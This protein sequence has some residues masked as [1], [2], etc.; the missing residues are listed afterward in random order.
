MNHELPDE[1]DQEMKTARNR[2]GRLIAWTVALLCSLIAF[3][4]VLPIWLFGWIA[5]HTL[6]LFRG[7]PSLVPMLAGLAL[8]AVK[9]PE[10]SIWIIL[11]VVAMTTCL[12]GHRETNFRNYGF[13][14]TLFVWACWILFA[15]NFWLGSNTSIETV[16]DPERPVVCLGDSLTDYG[17]PKEL[18]KLI[19]VPVSDFGFNGYTTE[20]GI[21]LL[22]EIIATNPQ[23]VIVELG[24]H[25]FKDGKSRAQTKENLTTIIETCIASGARVVL[26]EI[27]RGFISDPYYGLERELARKMDLQLIPDTMMRRLIFWSPIIPPGSLVGES[28]Q[29][30]KDGL[31]PNENGNQMM[32]RYVADSLEHIFG[33]E[34]L[35]SPN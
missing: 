7:R 22:E 19:S 11:L 28:M 10:P 15:V 26:V 20:D 29:N 18:E 5:F 35:L 32:A 34:I 6:L 21:G 2:V 12:V 16:L 17:Y 1:H 23:A 9:L 14:T 27:A 8:L 25:D 13:K 30:S 24:G 3:P 31:H 33:T 4:N